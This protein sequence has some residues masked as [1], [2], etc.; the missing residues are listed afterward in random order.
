MHHL[1]KALEDALSSYALAIT[2]YL[3]MIQIR[4]LEVRTETRAEV[5]RYAVR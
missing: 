3:Q 4:I 5:C 1:H 2:P